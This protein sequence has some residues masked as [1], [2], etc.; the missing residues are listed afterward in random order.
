GDT[1]LIDERFNR[2]KNPPDIENAILHL[3]GGDKPWELHSDYQPRDYFYWE[4]LLRSEWRDQIIGAMF[5]MLR[6]RERCHPRTSDCYRRILLRLKRDL[7]TR[8]FMVQSAKELVI[9]L[10]ELRYRF[11]RTSA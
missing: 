7:F 5:D 6:N 2:I 3:T 1:L 9:V 8:N 4:T 10:K 11:F